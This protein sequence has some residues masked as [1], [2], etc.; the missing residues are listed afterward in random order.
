MDSKSNE[1]FEVIEWAMRFLSLTR[2]DAVSCVSELSEIISEGAGIDE[3]PEYFTTNN[4]PFD[5][6]RSLIKKRELEVDTS[7]DEILDGDASSPDLTPDCIFDSPNQD[8][9]EFLL[10][11][12]LNCSAVRVGF[13]CFCISSS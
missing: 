9:V 13:F 2:D 4:I 1:E 5:Y 10:K 11:K 8:H 7:H 3:I 6:C 12:E